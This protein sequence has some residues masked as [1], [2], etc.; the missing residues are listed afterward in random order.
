MICIF[1][2]HLFQGAGALWRICP[3]FLLTPVS[4]RDLGLSERDAATLGWVL[5]GDSCG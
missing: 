5:T 2:Q 3:R 1:I 4:E